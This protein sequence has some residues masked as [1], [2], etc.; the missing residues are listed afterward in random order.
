MVLRLAVRDFVQPLRPS[1]S[2]E[3]GAGGV[4]MRKGAEWHLHI[5]Q[6]HSRSEPGYQRELSVRGELDLPRGRVE[7][8]GRIDGLFGD[9]PLLEEIKTGLGWAACPPELEDPQHPYRL[10]LL[11]Y[12]WLYRRAG[13][14]I[15]GLRLCLV[16]ALDG[17]EF[18]LDQPWDEQAVEEWVRNRAML[19]LEQA[20]EAAAAWDQRA[21]AA[22]AMRFPH[23]SWRAGQEQMLAA[24]E[25]AARQGE[26]LLLQ[27]PT[28]LGKTAACLFPA[29]RHGLLHNRPVLWLTAKTRQQVEVVAEAEKIRKSGT[30]IRLVVLPARE[31][32]C[33]NQELICHKDYCR[34]A[35]GHYDK[36]AQGGL[37][38]PIGA[39][40]S[41]SAI[42]ETDAQGPLLP[43]GA[44]EADQ[45]WWMLPETLRAAGER[46]EICPFQL[47][48]DLA[49]Q[50]DLL[51][52]DYNYFFSPHAGLLQEEA[53]K[54]IL[55]VDEVHNLARRVMDH[56]TFLLEPK[57]LE[58]YAAMAAHMSGRLA[59]LI[60][61]CLA[62]MKSRL[63]E[64]QS[65][66][67]GCPELNWDWANE[68]Q[69]LAEEAF[70]FYL[71][72]RKGLVSQ[73]PLLEWYRWTAEFGRIAAAWGPEFRSLWQGPE[74]GMLLLCC[75]PSRILQ[76]AW[77]SFHAFVGL[78][79]TLKPHGFH[80][81]LLGLPKNTRFLELP[82]AFP[83]ENRL[84]LLIPQI[85]SAL[86]QRSREAPRIAQL[87][88]RV[89]S[90]HP[91]HYGCFFPSFSFL[92]QVADHLADMGLRVLS[93]KP[94]MS[95]QA[96]E[97]LAARMKS[98]TKS[99]VLL[100]VQGGLLAE[101]CD[102]PGRQ[103]IGAFVIGPAL[104]QFNAQQETLRAYYEQRYGLGFAYAYAL[105]A[106]ARSI[107]AAG[108]VIR[109][110]G[111]RGTIILVDE[112]F[113]QAD[114]AQAFPAH[115]FQ[116]HPREWVPQSILARL[117]AFW[118]QPAEAK[119]GGSAG[120]RPGR[121]KVED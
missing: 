114:F 64:W 21:R 59:R 17:A 68:L 43:L 26:Q 62:L 47:G 80:L 117:Q 70:L 115:W 45:G 52:C 119:H 15:G 49:R 112:R 46:W 9:P 103:M 10:Q 72:K 77:S 105:P 40:P 39:A 91:G 48:L 108:R 79:A 67:R 107:Q 98:R 50:A 94:D 44:A 100:A 5:Q 120:D 4:G 109:G 63:A 92:N 29:L 33:L 1:G 23:R 28:G 93:Q 2:I 7:L 55:L 13:G 83:R 82:D 84:T 24:V 53:T 36:C 69:R 65:L 6:K 16:N 96:I 14:R 118:Q 12:A 3:L 27:A 97:A 30:P 76:P 113:L 99:L 19:H 88:Q 54:P 8:S 37:L 56:W 71:A 87:I 90:Q 85:S 86:R 116:Q 66:P 95:P 121:V 58:R 104:P 110:E 75:D 31:R 35:R 111:D 81:D 25:A 32:A 11:V 101:G 51:V 20:Q 73:D 42:A 89:V 74:Q 78:S 22:R 60:A 57:T 61:R 34:F 106:M 41:A 18:L 38:P 102:F